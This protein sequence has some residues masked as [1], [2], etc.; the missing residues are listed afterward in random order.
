MKKN[1]KIF[2][3]SLIFVWIAVAATV[4]WFSKQKDLP[5]KQEIIINKN[6]K[7]TPCGDGICDLLEKKDA[8]LCPQDCVNSVVNNVVKNNITQEDVVSHFGFLNA[9]GPSMA[10]LSEKWESNFNKDLIETSSDLMKDISAGWS[11]EFVFIY[12][13]D[14][15]DSYSLERFKK[16]K[17]NGTKLIITVGVEERQMN[18]IKYEEWLAGI[19]EYYSGYVKYWQVPN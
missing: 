6:E 10:K 5:Q 18:D 16:A 8:R 17:E 1:I 4:F 11:R 12:P 9:Y 2:L 15:K 3:F 19:L 13:S 7:I 14:Y